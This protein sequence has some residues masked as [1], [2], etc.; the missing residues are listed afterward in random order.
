VDAVFQATVA[1]GARGA[2]KPTDYGD[3]GRA[4]IIVDPQGAAVALWRG[5]DGDR[6]DVEQ[7]PVGDWVWDE[8]M[9]R[10]VKASMA[11][12]GKFFG[13]T[14]DTMDMG[15]GGMY[16]IVKTADGKARGGMMQAPDPA[17]KSVWVPYVHVANADAIAAKAEQLG[18]KP[19]MP[20]MEVPEIGRM[21]TVADPTGALFAFIQPAPR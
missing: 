18:G 9:S 12:Y 10:D 6:A 17:M 15:A 13:Y 21:T 16:Y 7:T 3:V 2:L 5:K 4:A 11:F 1:A 20:V 8:L 14:F 19:L